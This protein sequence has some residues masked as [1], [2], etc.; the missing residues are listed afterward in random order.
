M[1]QKITDGAAASTP[2][3]DLDEFDTSQYIAPATPYVTRSITWAVL[4]AQILLLVNWAF[5]TGTNGQT[6]KYNGTT[7]VATSDIFHGSGGS[8]NI[9]FGTTTPT[10]RVHALKAS[11]SM[12][13]LAIFGNTQNTG[14]NGIG[15]AVSIGNTTIGGVSNLGYA[16][17]YGEILDAFIKNSENEDS[18]VNIISHSKNEVANKGAICF[19]PDAKNDKPVTTVEP[20]FKIHKGGKLMWKEMVANGFSQTDG[21]KIV[22][23]VTA[24]KTATGDYLQVEIKGLTRYIPLFN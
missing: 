24:T 4:K 22:D 12:L 6:I 5:P 9:G 13:F 14:T 15:T 19:Y 21:F 10:A 17:D 23:K 1:G 18:N 7:P 3:N 16:N 20:P 11:A 2:L 8:G